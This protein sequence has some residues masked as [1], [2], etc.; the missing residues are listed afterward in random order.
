MHADRRRGPA[1][2]V[3]YYRSDTMPNLIYTARRFL[4]LVC[5]LVTGTAVTTVSQ[6]IANKQFISDSVQALA[7]AKYASTLAVSLSSAALAASPEKLIT[8]PADTQKRKRRSMQRQLILVIGCIDVLAYAAFCTGFAYCDGAVATLVL[9]GGGQLFTAIMSKYILKKQ[10]SQS[11]VLGVALV[12]IGLCIRGLGPLLSSS[13]ASTPMDEDARQRLYIGLA[14]LLFAS[15]AYSL[16]G[17]IYQTLV[18]TGDDPPSHSDIMLQSSIIGLAAMAG[19]EVFHV[20]PKW[21]FLVTKPMQTSGTTAG[22]ATFW[23]AAF[24]AVYNCHSYAAG[25]VFRSDGAQGVGIVNAMRGATVAL[26]SHALFCSPVK[27]LQCLT[28]SSAASAA[29][30]TTGGI[31]WVQGSRP[32]QER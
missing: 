18:S 1:R 13:Q 6:V 5:Y 23:L 8:I 17:V 30:V 27:P 24:G 2:V 4:P 9:A 25:M 20:L 31:V 29:T 3:Q 15:I 22:L 12:C 11:Q 32:D 19:Y 21:R 14:S 7:C 26:V 28:T 16:L 10:L